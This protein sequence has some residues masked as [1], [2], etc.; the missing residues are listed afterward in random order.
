MTDLARPSRLRAA[1]LS[2]RRWAGIGFLAALIGYGPGA[3]ADPLA[4]LV[5]IVNILFLTAL[6]ALLAFGY[7]LVRPR[8]LRRAAGEDPT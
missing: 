7:R 8:R 5:A 3:V 1:A 2:A 6:A 4:A